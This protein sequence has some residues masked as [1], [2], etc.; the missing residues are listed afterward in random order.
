MR[1]NIDFINRR[2]LWY[3]ISAILIAAGLVAMAVNWPQP[4]NFGIDFTGGNI[5]EIEFAQN[6]KS[7]QVRQVL[8]K[9]DL[10]NATIQAA[11]E[12]QYLLR[13]PELSEGD[14]NKIIAGLKENLG[15]AKILRS[16]KVG[17]VISKELTRKALYA[18]GIAWVLMVIYITIRFEFF[19]GLAAVLALIH[20]VLMTSGLF[21]IF[22]WEVDS[23]FV[24]A[25]LTIIG[26]SINDTIVIFDRIRENLKM[27]KKESLEDLVNKSINQTL[28]RSINT[29]MTVIL[30]L[31][32]LL[33]LGGETT[34]GFALAMLIGV[35]SGTYS[36]ICVASPLW[37]DFRHYARERR[38]AAARVK[39]ATS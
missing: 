13:V 33:F 37:I 23:A 16:D 12:R 7:V 39:K 10:S 2:R 17:G 21:A 6:V 19:F 20:D 36:S 35:I 3:I 30:A 22:R 8:E 9:L 15:E 24:A 5:I 27:R 25:I 28:T 4:L 26:Y 11:G 18:T 29:V 1:F 34:R 31:L 38:R 14:Y 32:A